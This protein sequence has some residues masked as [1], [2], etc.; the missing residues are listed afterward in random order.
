MGRSGRAGVLPRKWGGGGVKN[1]RLASDAGMADMA[2][3]AMVRMV[4]PV[5]AGGAGGD[6]DDYD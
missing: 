1:K 3:M 4:V 2:G 5:G 6:D